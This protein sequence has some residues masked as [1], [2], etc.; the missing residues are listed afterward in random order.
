[1]SS[2]KIDITGTWLEKDIEAKQASGG[3]TSIHH[4]H[5]NDELD[6]NSK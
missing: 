4:E 2:R 5:D 1:M 3:M 6:R